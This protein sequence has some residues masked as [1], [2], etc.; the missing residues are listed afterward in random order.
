ME[1]KIKRCQ[2]SFNEYKLAYPKN[3]YWVLPVKYLHTS[4][5]DFV[6]ATGFSST[7]CKENATETGNFEKGL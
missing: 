5:E 4:L 1:D 3:M 7:E 6:L 2:E